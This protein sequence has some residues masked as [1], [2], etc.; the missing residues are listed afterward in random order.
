MFRN[1]NL[2]TWGPVTTLAVTAVLVILIG[3]LAEVVTSDYTFR[4]FLEDV[5]WVAMAAVGAAGVGRG[6]RLQGTPPPGT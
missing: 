1:V 4:G 2:S 6:L 3:G 5:K